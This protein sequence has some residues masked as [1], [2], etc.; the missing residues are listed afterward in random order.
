MLFPL[1]EISIIIN[2]YNPWG[3]TRKKIWTGGVTI[4]ANEKCYQLIFIFLT[5]LDG[6][7][8]FQVIARLFPRFPLNY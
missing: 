4:S 2:H 1:A 6:I 7:I 3:G 5:K 8:I